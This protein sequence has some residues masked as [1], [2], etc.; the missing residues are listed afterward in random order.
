[1]G[2]ENPLRNVQSN[3]CNDFM[4]YSPWRELTNSL[5]RGGSI[6]DH[7]VSQPLP[8]GNHLHLTFLHPQIVDTLCVGSEIGNGYS[9]LTN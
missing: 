4:A 6:P 2:M 1:M 7:C 9:L 8:R 3:C 5:V